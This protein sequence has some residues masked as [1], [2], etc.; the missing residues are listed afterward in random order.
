MGS[1]VPNVGLSMRTQ[2]TPTARQFTML[3]AKRSI[4]NERPGILL[5]ISNNLSILEHAPSRVEQHGISIIVPR[6]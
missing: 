1:I 5:G 3:E 2:N 4:V 6:T